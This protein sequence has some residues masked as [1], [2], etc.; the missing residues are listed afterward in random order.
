MSLCRFVQIDY[1]TLKKHI[2]N[3]DEYVYHS[4]TIGEHY[5][6]API[7][8]KNCQ[9]SRVGYE[10]WRVCF[11]SKRTRCCSRSPQLVSSTYIT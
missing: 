9:Y 6:Y 1:K 7:L 10:N 3:N 5:N 11:V 4:E 2:D 8:F